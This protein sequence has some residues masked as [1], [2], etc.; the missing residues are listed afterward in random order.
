[1]YKCKCQYC[2]EIKTVENIESN[3]PVLFLKLLIQSRYIM[4]NMCL[5]KFKKNGSLTSK[6]GKCTIIIG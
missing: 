2:E 1:M 5:N 3:F 4:C 6:D